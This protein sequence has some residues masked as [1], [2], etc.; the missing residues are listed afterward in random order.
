MKPPISENDLRIIRLHCD[1]ARRTG[2]TA[3]TL[4]HRRDNLRRLAERLP[5][6]LLD[7]TADDLDRWQ[8]HLTCALSSVQTYTAHVRTLYRWAV[9]SG[10]LDGDPSGRLPRPKI[11]QRLARPIPEADLRVLLGA[12]QEPLR[13]WLVLAG[14]MGLRA[15]EIAQIRREDIT[16]REGRM[17]LTGVGKGRKPFTLAVPAQVV[18]DLAA[19]FS[20]RRG[21]L[22][23]TVAGGRLSAQTVTNSATALMRA[24]GMPYTLHCLRHRFGTRLYGQTKDILLT[25]EAMRHASP[26]TTRLYVATVN[27]QTVAAMDRLA[28]SLRPK[29]TTRRRRPPTPESEA[30]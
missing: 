28:R 21:P 19:H 23:R 20:A 2:A 30:A 7:A 1:W 17:Y 6:E 18:P 9:Q 27:G 13:T 4:K 5:C 11:P 12:A 8:S 14:F 29:Q 10:H 16:D 25:Q 24:L 22:W 15:H 3:D 26:N